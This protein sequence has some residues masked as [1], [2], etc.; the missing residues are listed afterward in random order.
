MSELKYLTCCVVDSGGYPEIAIELAKYFGTVYYFMEW[1]EPFPTYHKRVVGTGIPNVTR[2][3]NLDDYKNSVDFWYF[4]DLFYGAMA[5]KLRD[6]GQIVFGAGKG[7]ELE[8]D[9]KKFKDMMNEMGMPVNEYVELIGVT[10]LENYLKENPDVYVKLNADMRGHLES[11][12]CE[13]YELFKPVLDSLRHN[14][15]WDSETAEF[16][17]EKPIRPAIEYGYDGSFNGHAYPNKT[18]FG[19]EIKDT[20]YGCVVVDY[21][22]LPKPVKEYNEK[23][24][25]IL[26]SYDYRGFIGNEIRHQIKG[27]AFLIDIY[28]R[29]GQPPTSLQIRLIDNF[30]QFAFDTA[31]G[32]N[33]NM[34]YKFKYGVQLV[35]KSDWART[36]PQAIYFPPEFADF[37]SIKNLAIKDG[38][39][40]YV[41]QTGC[42]M[43]EIG[44]CIGMGETFKEAKKQCIKIAE[45][46]KG[47]GIKINMD[48]LEEAQS[49]IDK[50]KTIGINIF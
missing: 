7:E 23:F 43:E 11:S 40:Y 50:L 28:C 41:P 32:R 6:E 42:E 47:Y 33:V 48:A 39:W 30:G 18:T 8:L 10:N 46:I 20:S 37:I 12:H 34:Q 35:I 24:K 9:R 19:I 45:S 17:V 38:V 14:L 1:R 25:P 3:Y 27:E 36:E 4:T 44:A 16:L 2:I 21:E 13:T 31:L 15:G 49:E 26:E 22:R 5:S 29:Q